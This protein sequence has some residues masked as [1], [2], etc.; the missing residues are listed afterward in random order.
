MKNVVN[1]TQQIDSRIRVI[2]NYAFATVV[3]KFTDNSGRDVMVTLDMESA[4]TMLAFM[5]NGPTI[6]KMRPW[7]KFW[8]AK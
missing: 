1:I 8:S 4:I 7:W 6:T 5:D 2:P 3:L